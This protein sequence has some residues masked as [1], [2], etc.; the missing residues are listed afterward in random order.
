MFTELD[1]RDCVSKE[2]LQEEKGGNG[3]ERKS[4]LPC[5][6]FYIKHILALANRLGNNKVRQTSQL[7]CGC[8]SEG[9]SVCMR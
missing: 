3:N 1:L 2:D 7:A 6:R 9:V 5:M 4:R 8:L